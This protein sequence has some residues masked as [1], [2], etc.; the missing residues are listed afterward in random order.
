[1]DE[2]TNIIKLKRQKY[3]QK[4]KEKILLKNKQYYEFRKKTLIAKQKEYSK[5]YYQA[6]KDKILKQVKLYQ[7]LNRTKY[8]ETAR[9][10]YRNKKIKKIKEY[11]SNPD[12]SISYV[13]VKT[14][15]INKHLAELLIKKEEFKKKLLEEQNK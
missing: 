3:Y 1:M 13:T 4:N 15:E 11:G 12:A 5:Q 10:Y 7:M 14:A 9:K 6:N 8:R 2:L